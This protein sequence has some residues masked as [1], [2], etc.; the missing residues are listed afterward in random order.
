MSVVNYSNE[1]LRSYARILSRSA[2]GGLIRENNTTY[3]KQ[4]VAK[5]D[6]DKLGYT[7]RDF[8]SYTFKTLS[9]HYRNEYVYKCYLINK[10]LLGKY[11]LNTSIALNE[12]K[13]ENSIADIVILNGT[14]KVFEIKT[15]L[16]SPVRLASQIENY[17]K[18]FEQ[19]YIVTHETLRDKYAKI[20]PEGI[21]LIVLTK[22]DTLRTIVEAEKN[23]DFNNLSIMKCLRKHEYSNIIF[24]YFKLLPSVPPIHFYKACQKLFS[25]IPSDLVHNLM[26]CELKKRELK[27]PKKLI[28]PEIPFEIKT[29]CLSLNFSK[30]EYSKLES[31][32]DSSII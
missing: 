3:I 10:L 13:V 12:F 27:C 11:S 19:I 30:N 6:A 23:S 28:S 31:I 29:M 21:G 24:N 5:Y 9:T 8:F 14:S 15:E 20:L 4:K 1:R 32:L 17:K 2:I 16:D 18:V 26:L 7:Y 22:R 25:Q